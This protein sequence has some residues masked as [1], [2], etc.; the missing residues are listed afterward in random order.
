MTEQ[1]LL[2]FDAALCGRRPGP[3]ELHRRVRLYSDRVAWLRRCAKTLTSRRSLD[4]RTIFDDVGVAD[5]AFVDCGRRAA[6]HGVPTALRGYCFGHVKQ[7]RR[8]GSMRELGGAGGRG[9]P[10]MRRAACG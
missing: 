4:R 10:K 6:T 5:C 8:H 9:K 7:F 1:L 3:R 2:E